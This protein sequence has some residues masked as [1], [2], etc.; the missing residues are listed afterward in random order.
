MTAG[1]PSKYDARYCQE[2]IAYAKSSSDA[3][4]TLEG[5]ADLIDVD[6][7]TITAW[8]SSHPEFLGAC[9][10]VMGMQKA[11]LIDR[12]LKGEHNPAIT[13][14]LLKNNHGMKDKVEQELS[15]P[16]GGPIETKSKL[17]MT[18]LSD[19]QLRAIASIKA[20]S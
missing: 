3:I 7:D 2:L 11:R 8:Q 12:G 6:P 19:D 5:F 1:R 16:N 18:G 17:D 9:K 14:F 15:G 10:K 20:D 13:I 4:P